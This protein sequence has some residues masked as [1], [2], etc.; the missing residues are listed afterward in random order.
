MIMIV[1]LISGIFVVLVGAALLGVQPDFRRPSR[2]RR[3][4]IRSWLVESG[5]TWSP[6]K[7]A[8][9]TGLT[10]IGAWLLFGT[11]SASPMVGLFPGVAAASFVPLSL[12]R[13]RERRL[14][15]VREA[16]PD[17][18]RDLVGSV[19]S[20]M[21]LGRALE[22]LADRG[23]ARLRDVFSGYPLTARTVGVVPALEMVKERLGDAT[24]DRVL[25]VLILAY[26][27]GGTVVVDILKDLASAITKDVWALEEIRSEAL[28]QKINARAVFG[29]PWLVLVALTVR[30]GAFR[31]FYQTPGGLLVITV[32][33]VLSA[34]GMWLV[35]RLGRDPSEPRVFRS[36]E[37]AP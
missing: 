9:V 20:G 14:A 16:W 3:D 4:R 8:V 10:G 1:S 28:E 11:I 32:A 35:I 2:T 33:A 37:A 36:D 23:P 24:S 5:S 27:R 26:E 21:S 22:R 18:L 12:S 30:D 7:L 34:L 31:A 15:G 6:S 13:R 29:L 17:G 25:E 19:S